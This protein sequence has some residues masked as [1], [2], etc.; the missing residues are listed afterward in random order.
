MTT[1]TIKSTTTAISEAP[2]IAKPE[3]STTVAN[4]LAA[5]AVE[6]NDT[7]RK[8]VSPS[9][10]FA[11]TTD[12]T[13]YRSQCEIIRLSISKRDINPRDNIANKPFTPVLTLTIVYRLMSLVVDCF[14]F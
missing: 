13:L 2:N 4:K 5:L 6:T 8:A 10:G 12:L 7:G 1:T 3:I 14:V 9:F 11:T